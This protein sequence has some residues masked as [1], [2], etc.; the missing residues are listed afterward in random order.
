MRGRKPKPTALK[1]IE[2]N[3]GKR[4]INGSEPKPPTSQPTCPAHLSPT[5]KTEWKRLATV[6]NEIGLLTQIDRT[7]LAA[8]CQ[9]Y[10]RWV[11][12]E[13]KL[14][15]TPPLIKTP[16]GYVQVSPWITISNKQVELMTRLMAELGLS[17]SARSRLAI[18]VPNGA[19]PW[20]FR[21]AFE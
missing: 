17:P 21:V 11:E 12:A 19:K 7:V 15:E 9:A 1:L 18:Q 5:A 10:G 13:R 8:Y 3:P 16:A 6:L 20:E 2:G 4:P 14:A